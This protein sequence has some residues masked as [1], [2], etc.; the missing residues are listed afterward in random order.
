MMMNCAASTRQVTDSM[1]LCPAPDKT[2]G[3]QT[4]RACRLLL[5]LAPSGMPSRTGS[6]QVIPD[7]SVSG[8]RQDRGATDTETVTVAHGW[9]QAECRVAQLLVDC[10]CGWDKV[11]RSFIV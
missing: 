1:S 6:F 4:Q 9:H 3:L 8:P 5:W 11:G 7:V 10:Y 2:G